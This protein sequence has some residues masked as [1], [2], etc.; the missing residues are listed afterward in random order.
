LVEDRLTLDDA[1]SLVPL[2]KNGRDSGRLEALFG[3]DQN[4]T[5]FGR[6]TY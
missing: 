3:E 4:A 6:F 2:F 5:M 1:F